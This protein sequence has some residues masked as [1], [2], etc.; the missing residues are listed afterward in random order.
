MD[1]V[2]EM[3]KKRAL[4]EIMIMNNG[5]RVETKE[6]FERRREEIK[7]LLQEHEYG[8]IPEKPDH[9]CV[10]T[11]SENTNFCAGKAP[12]KELEFTVTVG[13]KSYTFPVFSIIPKDKKNLPAFVSLNFDDQAANK[14]LPVEEIC[15]RGFAVFALGCERITKDNPDMKDGIAPLFVGKRRKI[16]DPGKIAMWAWCAMRIMDY[17]FFLDGIDRDSIA[18]IGHGLLGDAALLAGAFDERFKYVI[19][20]GYGAWK[21]GEHLFCKRYQSCQSKQDKSLI[22]KD[23]LAFLVS[24]RHLMV[25]YG[26]EEDYKSE[27]SSAGLCRCSVNHHVRRGGSYLSREDWN[28]Y[29]DFI[30]KMSKDTH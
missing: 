10:K 27:F 29:M 19:K 2:K 17:V 5:K 22:L 30:Q 20:N 23:S 21:I 8:Y 24:P 13:K 16:S 25:G 1:F 28:I 9:L 18:L 14:Y 26:E 15:D 12:L 3:A 7:I 6:D 4:P 11:L